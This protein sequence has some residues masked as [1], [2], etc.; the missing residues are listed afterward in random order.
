MP[1]ASDTTSR[2]SFWTRSAG[3]RLGGSRRHA[4][5]LC[6]VEAHRYALEQNI[7]ELVEFERWAGRH[8]LE[9]GCGIAT[10]AMQFVR[11]ERATPASNSVQRR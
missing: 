6:Q 1:A 8:V 9:A 2:R 4:G 7:L 11:P 3:V 10:D 5:V